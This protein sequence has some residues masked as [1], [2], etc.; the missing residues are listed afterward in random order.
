MSKIIPNK[1]KVNIKVIGVG[2]GGCNAVDHMSDET[3]EGVSFY[4]LNTDIQALTNKNIEHKIQ[5]GE[6]VSRGLGAGSVPEIGRLAA[7]ESEEQIK[8][9][10]TDTDMVFITAGM[11]GGTG[12][13][14]APVV[15][16][17][18]KDLGVLTVAIVTKPFSFENRTKAAMNGIDLLSEYCDCMLV[19]PN[20]NLTKINKDISLIDMFSEVDDV[21]LK[22]AK[23]IA[24]II[25]KSSLVNVDFADVKKVM[26]F[27]GKAMLGMGFAT[28]ENKIIDATKNAIETPILE[29]KT[30]K[31]AKG[32][33]VNIV[34]D[35]NF[36]VTDLEDIGDLIRKE[37]DDDAII[38]TGLSIDN[39]FDDG[40]RVTVVAT[41]IDESLE[42]EEYFFKK[43]I[44]KLENRS[45]KNRDSEIKVEES[46][47]TTKSNT[48][49]PNLKSPS[50]E[51]KPEGNGKSDI[52][53][54]P[55][56]LRKQSK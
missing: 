11:G 30:I 38:I 46:N 47:V 24:E 42:D 52:L 3:I 41:D 19:I 10:L 20:G 35:I 53:D 23:G 22:S 34:G 28:G 45:F 16:K 39:E 21:L 17:I 55:A 4:G 29:T 54:I 12:T 15:A 1:N 44:D 48:F 18:A 49:N 14:A 37:V 33:L 36:S 56:F 5:I 32:V 43:D 7:E 31:G 6:S 2:G 13:G 9:I 50:K 25:T 8:D 51:E 27:R 40:V 26:T